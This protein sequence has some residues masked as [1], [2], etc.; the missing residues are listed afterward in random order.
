MPKMSL[1]F[2]MIQGTPEWHEWR[3]QGIGA[4]EMAAILGVCKYS[5]PYKVWCEK[6]GRSKGFEGNFVTERGNE[7]EAKARARYE[8]V[9]L[10][11]MPPG[12]A[13]HP[14]YQILRASLDGIRADGKRILEIKCPGRESHEAALSGRVPDH[15]IPQVQYQLLVTG[16]DECEYF[17]FYIDRDGNEGHASVTVRPDLEYQGM[18]VARALQFWELVKSDTQPALTEHDDLVVDCG[19]V[20]DICKTLTEQKDQLSKKELDQ[21]KERVIRLGG[22]TRIRCGSV[23]VTKSQTSSGKDSYRLT[24]SKTQV[25]A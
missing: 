22:H 16:A 25:T 19:E 5:T 3:K 11:D 17:S 6:T 4:S 18:L 14:K 1:G 15:Y 12:C 21:M 9:S 23:L 10:E 8:L 13:V 7:L 24:I 20:L 2:S